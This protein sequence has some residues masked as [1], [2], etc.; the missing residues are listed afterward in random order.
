MLTY[1]YLKNIKDAIDIDDLEEDFIL[2]L[3]IPFIFLL[4]IILILFQPIYFLAYKYLSKG[5]DE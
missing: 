3:L 2:F 5:D 4:D 1:L